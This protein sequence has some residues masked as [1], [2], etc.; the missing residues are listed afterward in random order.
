[1]FR[2]QPQVPVLRT[3]DRGNDPTVELE[4]ANGVAQRLSA[5]VFLAR[6]TLSNSLTL[7]RRL[8]DNPDRTR[9]IGQL[10]S[11]LLQA[12]SSLT[13]LKED[14]RDWN[15]NPNQEIQADIHMATDNAQSLAVQIDNLFMNFSRS[16]QQESE[17]VRQ[18]RELSY[19]RA[20]AWSYAM[21][22]VGCLLSIL[23]KMGNTE[24]RTLKGDSVEEEP[25]E[26]AIE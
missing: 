25:V 14:M 8:P 3:I 6:T 5:N 24:S 1:M 7:Q 17:K 10:N 11:L 20:N 21:Y 18:D 26:E 2:T 9:L 15:N 23:G 16:L 13:V 19:A 12:D 4:R 22:A